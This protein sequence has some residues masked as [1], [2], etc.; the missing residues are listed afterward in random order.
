MRI[1]CG[2]SIFTGA[3]RAALGGRR[4]A[5]APRRGLLHDRSGP[6]A[7]GHAAG[8]PRSTQAGRA[9]MMDIRWIGP[10]ALPVSP[11]SPNGVRTR[12]STLRGWCPR[13]LDDGTVGRGP[14]GIVATDPRRTSRP[15]G[16]VAAWDSVRV[17]ALAGASIDHRRTSHRTRG[18]SVGCGPCA[19][20][21]DAARLLARP[22]MLMIAIAAVVAG[23]G[24]APPERTPSPGLIASPGT[25]S[26][27]RSR[28]YRADGRGRRSRPSRPRSGKARST[29]N[30]GSASRH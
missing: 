14:A 2:K 20:A 18:V 10:C 12:V 6:R 19:T 16:P 15:A 26:R 8:N 22:P 13:P 5:E 11:R 3:V 25:R 4:A 21:R 7:W 24:V 1:D 30:A 23:I 28:R 29:P 9:L 27:T 17:P